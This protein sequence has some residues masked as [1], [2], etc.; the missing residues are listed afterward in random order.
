MEHKKVIAVA[1]GVSATVVLFAIVYG[2]FATK[3]AMAPSVPA[4]QQQKKMVGENGSA[5]QQAMPGANPE[6]V[7]DIT[8]AIDAQLAEDAKALDAEIAAETAD[9]EGEIASLNELNATY[10]ENAY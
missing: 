9:I 5:T 7:T 8:A 6:T 2:Q 3:N 1:L 10:D 4:A